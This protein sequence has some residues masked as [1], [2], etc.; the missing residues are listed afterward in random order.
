MKKVSW[1]TI[2]CMGTGKRFSAYF[3]PVISKLHVIVLK[4]VA[5]MSHDVAIIL[6]AY[7]YLHAEFLS[8]HSSLKI[9][10]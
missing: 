8:R 5:Y 1:T 10:L 9:Y 3:C 4:T 2:A 6:L 7:M